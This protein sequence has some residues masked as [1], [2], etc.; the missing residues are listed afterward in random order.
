MQFCCHD[1]LPGIMPRFRLLIVFVTSLL[2]TMISVGSAQ[3]SPL[4]EWIGAPGST[5]V[6]SAQLNAR[7]S[8]AAYFNP[9]RLAAV[10]ERKFHF[11]LLGVAGRLRIDLD[12]RPG[13]VDIGD[14]IYSARI[15]GEDGLRRPPSERPLPTGELPR[16]RGS[17]DPSFSRQYAVLGTTVPLLQGRLVLGMLTTL[18]ADYFALQQPHFADERE[19]YFSN[20]LHFERMG[21]RLTGS[22]FAAGVGVEIIE[23]LRLGLG[24]TLAQDA[25]SQNQIYSPD[26]TDQ[27][28]SEVNAAVRISTRLVPHFG[29]DASPLPQWTL[30]ATVHAPYENRV[31]G[32][33]ELRFWN[34]PAYADGEDSVQQEFTY[35]YDFEPLRASLGSAYQWQT[36]EGG[37]GVKVGAQISYGRWSD[38]VDRHGDEP[39]LPWRD[40]WSPA[41]SAGWW[42]GTAE[43]DGELSFSPSPVPLQEGRSN[44]VD[45]SRWIAA[46]GWARSLTLFDQNLRLGVQGQ[47]QWLRE[48]RVVKSESSQDPVRD[49]FPLSE[50][51]RTGETIEASLDF[52]TNNPG[53]P[54]FRA[55]GFLV[56]GGLF[57]EALF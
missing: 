57:L 29:V 56:S 18:S 37:R 11:G 5:Q 27:E 47:V 2:A 24:F 16:E 15:E 53:Y 1:I 39:G 42:N 50:D 44:Y 25:E 40:I 6:R 17:H 31:V 12:D 20:S 41:L 7:G 51:A 13:G 10:E 55:S 54:G 33:S 34:F 4:W 35:V 9:A 38:Y 19:Q 30:T 21:D 14:E 26:A 22:H 32:R 3:A 28:Q 8:D 46:A 48:Q 36:D 43:V 23:S 52:R 49:E 45:N